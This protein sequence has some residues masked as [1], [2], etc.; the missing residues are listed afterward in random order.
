MY[1]CMHACMETNT[2][3]MYICMRACI[4]VWKRIQHLCIYV[5]VHACMYGNEYNIYV[6]MY[7]CMHACM[8]TNTT[9]MYICMRAC[10][11][12]YFLLFHFTVGWRL[13]Y[14]ISSSPLYGS[15]FTFGHNAVNMCIIGCQGIDRIL[16]NFRCPVIGVPR[17]H[18]V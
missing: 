11:A 18:Y 2:T 9:S 12:F 8:E 6:Y 15:T 13:P 17:L 1:A 10:M 14:T 7:A 5:W 16:F 4:R 3:S